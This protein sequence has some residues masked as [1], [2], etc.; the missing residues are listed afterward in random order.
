MRGWL[1]E[2]EAGCLLGVEDANEEGDRDER[3]EAD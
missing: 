3:A 1:L 2:E